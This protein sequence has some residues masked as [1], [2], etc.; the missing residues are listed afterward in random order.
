MA[1]RAT[2]LSGPEQGPR[3]EESGFP[4]PQ[5][6]EEQ[7]AGRDLEEARDHHRV[8][9]LERGLP[10]REAENHG[11]GDEGR[12]TVDDRDMSAEGKTVPEPRREQPVEDRAAQG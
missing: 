8:G 4:G 7:G 3:K 5:V 12:Q 6:G 2:S 10:E 1:S 9:E 11:V